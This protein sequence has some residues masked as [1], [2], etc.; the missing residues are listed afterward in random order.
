MGAGNGNLYSQGVTIKNVTVNNA[1]RNGISVISA[2]NLLID[3]CTI[4]NTA[5]TLPKDGIDF[6]P[7][8]HTGVLQNCT[9]R[10][11][12]I[13]ANSGDGIEFCLTYMT[14]AASYTMT[15]SSLEKLTIVGNG[16]ENIDDRTSGLVMDKFMPGLTIKNLLVGENAQVG[17]VGPPNYDD[18]YY[19]SPQANVVKYIA[20]LGQPDGPC[21]LRQIEWHHPNRHY[22]D[23]L[24]DGHQ[25]SVLHV[26]GPELCLGDHTRRQRRQLYGGKARGGCTRT[27]HHHP[28][29]H[30]CRQ[31]ACLR[32]A[33]ANTDGIA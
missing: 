22:A 29:R 8:D 5:G 20:S 30:R 12:I 3:N 1:Y 7:D 10:N 13:D 23:V 9:V 26:F 11:S 33:K 21:V 4:V 25:Q 32:L 16:S 2:K 19:I 27:V 24:L 6:E 15:G 31:P 14:D 18:P 17:I 28:P